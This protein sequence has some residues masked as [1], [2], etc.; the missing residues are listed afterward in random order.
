[1][2]YAILIL[3][4]YHIYNCYS[5]CMHNSCQHALVDPSN[6]ICPSHASQP[7]IIFDNVHPAST[8]TVRPASQLILPDSYT[9]YKLCKEPVNQTYRK[10]S[11]YTLLVSVC[12]G[13]DAVD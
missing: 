7:P 12:D 1:M 5:K 10:R 6:I 8:C 9:Q 2:G 3:D 13:H 4:I 11:N